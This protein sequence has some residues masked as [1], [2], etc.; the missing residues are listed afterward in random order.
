MMSSGYPSRVPSP[1][2]S[3]DDALEIQIMEE[4]FNAPPTPSSSSSSDEESPAPSSSMKPMIMS[5]VS[6]LTITS[7]DS[8]RK[9]LSPIRPS[10]YPVAYWST[11]TGTR[12]TRTMVRTRPPRKD[13]AASLHPMPVESAPEYLSW[14]HRRKVPAHPLNILIHLRGS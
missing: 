3:P 12:T 7:E 14:T 4:L 1:A 6:K 11:K 10:R 9:D 2:S 5:H 8:I 13:L